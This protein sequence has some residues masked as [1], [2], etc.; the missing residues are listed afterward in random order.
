MSRI[1]FTDIVQKAYG[2]FYDTTTQAA[3]SA[4]TAYPITLNTTDLSNG[5]TVNSSS[6]TF[7]QDGIYNVQ[8]S[9]Q[10][11]DTGTANYKF[12]LKKNGQNLFGTTGTI[13]VTNQDHYALPAWNY[14]VNLNANDVL[15]FYWQSDSNSASLV[16]AASAGNYPSCFSMIVTAVQI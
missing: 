14:F 2:S 3:T 15:Q 10:T 8:W 1:S 11:G 16:Y 12:W 5:V 9:A 7:L 13:S 6:I 4:N